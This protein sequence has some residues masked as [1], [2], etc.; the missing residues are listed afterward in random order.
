MA[1]LTAFTKKALRIDKKRDAA[2]L[3][4]KI[5]ENE[6]PP[7]RRNFFRLDCHIPIQFNW[8]DKD[9]QSRQGCSEP[10]DGL[11]C[12]LSGGGVRLTTEFEMEEKD[13]ITFYLNLDGDEFFLSGEVQQE[14]RSAGRDS[15]GDSGANSNAYLDAHS[16]TVHSFQYG[17]MF[18]G[19][20]IVDQDRII[21]YLFQQQKLRVRL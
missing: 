5:H 20:S 12:N 6:A 3:L 15:D 13:C 16:D 10:Y 21:R 8:L 18:I 9:F 11:I 7:Q 4:Q 1:I 19:I 2:K 17:I 14:Y